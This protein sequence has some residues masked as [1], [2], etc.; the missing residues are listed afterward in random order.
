M[1]TVVRA[2]G[3]AIKVYGPPREHGPPHVHVERGSTGVVVIRLAIESTPARIWRV[4][5]LTNREVL[6]AYR[7]VEQYETEIRDMWRRIHGSE[8]AD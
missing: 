1:P 5:G 6:A 4:Y 8:T 7:L 3:F 2:G